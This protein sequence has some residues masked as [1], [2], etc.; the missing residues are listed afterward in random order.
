MYDLSSLT[1]DQTCALVLEAQSLN[2][3]T[4][5]DVPN[6]HIFTVSLLILLWALWIGNW[7]IRFCSV[8]MQRQ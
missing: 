3:W 5:R 7:I 2:Y 8:T 4:A 6:S 1:R